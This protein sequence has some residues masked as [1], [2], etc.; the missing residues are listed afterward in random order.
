M[1]VSVAREY[2]NGGDD[3]VGEHLPMIFPPFFNVDNHNLLEP[4]SVLNK[5]IP[6]P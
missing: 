1:V 3:V 5:Y 4:E 6:L 2:Q